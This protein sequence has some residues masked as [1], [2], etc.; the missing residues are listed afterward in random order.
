MGKC[1]CRF[2]LA[3]YPIRVHKDGFTDPP[4]QWV[5]VKKAD[6]TQARFEL[7]PLGNLAALQISGAQPGTTIIST[8][9]LWRRLVPM[10]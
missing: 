7:L 1:A 4:P 6:V 9:I 10:A 8:M 3:R 5:E 2:A